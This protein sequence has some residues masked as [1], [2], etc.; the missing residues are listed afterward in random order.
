[1]CIYIVLCRIRFEV[2]ALYMCMYLSLKPLSCHA[3]G[4]V[5]SHRTKLM[6]L[7]RLCETTQAVGSYALK[8]GSCV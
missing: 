5:S 1:M 6:C 8:V 3:C 4:S 2:N 7:L